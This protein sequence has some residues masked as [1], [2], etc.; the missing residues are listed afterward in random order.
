[1]NVRLVHFDTL[2]NKETLTFLLKTFAHYFSAKNP[3]VSNSKRQNFAK[4]I[5]FLSSHKQRHTKH[6]GFA[7]FSPQKHG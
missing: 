6:W 5:R 3:D 1:M 4:F 2:S 7:Y